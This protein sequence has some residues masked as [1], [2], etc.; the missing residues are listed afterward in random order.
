MATLSVSVRREPDGSSASFDDAASH[1]DSTGARP[2]I[3]DHSATERELA[4]SKRRQITICERSTAQRREEPVGQSMAGT[5]DAH[6]EHC[7]QDSLATIRFEARRTRIGS[8]RRGQTQAFRTTGQPEF[9]R[10]QV[11][12][13]RRFRFRF[14]RFDHPRLGESVHRRDH[15]QRGQHNLK[16]TR[17][18]QQAA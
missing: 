12:L 4:E 11:L 18:P 16:A 7:T 17:H 2:R 6:G 15:Q 3:D 8:T 14:R 13:D 1:A 10:V 5:H 9:R